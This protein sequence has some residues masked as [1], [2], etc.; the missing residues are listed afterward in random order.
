[1]LMEI[2]FAVPFNV[3]AKRYGYDIASDAESSVSTRRCVD[4]ELVFKACRQEIPENYQ[5]HCAVDKCLDPAAWEDESGN[6]LDNEALTLRIYQEIVLPL[7]TELGQAFTS[8]PIDELDRIAQGLNFPNWDQDVQLWGHQETAMTSSDHL[9]GYVQTHAAQ[10]IKITPLGHSQQVSS[11]GSSH[12]HLGSPQ[13][14]L[15]VNGTPPPTYDASQKILKDVG[16]IRYQASRFFDDEMPSEAHT[17][18]ARLNYRNWKRIYQDVYEKFIKPSS[19]NAVSSVKIAILDTGVDLSHPDFEARV[20]NIKGKYNWLSPNSNKPHVI[21]DRNGHG[22]FA[23]SLILDYAPDA[24]LYIAKIAES[25]PSSAGIIAKAINHAVS[26]WEV[27][28]ISMSF[29]FPTCNTADYHELEA[30]LAHAHAN[31]V[32]L[33]AAAS[34][35]GGKLG[36]AYPARDQHVIAIHSTDT[37]GNRSALSPTAMDHDINLATVGEAVE[38][39]WPVYLS[40]ETSNP[41]F[42]KYKSGTSYATPIAAGIA[43]FLLLYSRIYLPDKASA[44]KNRQKMQALLRQ[45]AEKER[46]QTVRDGYYFIDLS[47]YADCLF[48]K[49]LDFI[50]ATIRN[51]LST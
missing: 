51:V 16:S 50:D 49:S 43:G 22:T 8:M 26:T 2:Y 42:V 37:N 24:Q 10:E 12:R 30:A 19:L 41:N 18:E 5:F 20:D 4:V 29:G 47:L 31:R 7:E 33:F 46:G 14:N 39:A 23:A 36:H 40:D 34:N 1:M 9:N 32:L 25:E 27:D 28:I 15:Y 13:W 21:T 48:G 17:D 45:I 11:T 35:S 6:K 3:L 38:S 44:L